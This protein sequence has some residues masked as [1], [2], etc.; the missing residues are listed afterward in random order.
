[1]IDPTPQIQL[2]EP[3]RI[4]EW[5][6]IQCQPESEKRGLLAFFLEAQ[7]ADRPLAACGHQK[8][9]M[10]PSQSRFCRWQD[11]FAWES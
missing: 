8:E 11:I 10:S 6:G 9:P 3:L 4:N 1:M 2:S 5:L 7:P